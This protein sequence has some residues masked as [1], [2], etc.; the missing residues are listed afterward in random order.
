MLQRKF[1]PVF[2]LKDLVINIPIDI[3]RLWRVSF[4]CRGDG[5]AIEFQ[6]GPLVALKFYRVNIVA[7]QRLGFGDFC[8]AQVLLGIEFQCRNVGAR[9]W[10]ERSSTPRPRSTSAAGQMNSSPISGEIHQ[11]ACNVT[12]NV[13]GALEHLG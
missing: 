8:V 6:Q 3:A 5:D 1:R 7:G 12:D 9:A 11:I 2:H 10:P 13:L 4:R